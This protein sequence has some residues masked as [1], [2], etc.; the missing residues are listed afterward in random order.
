MRASR[1][2]RGDPFNHIGACPPTVITKVDGEAGTGHLDCPA[3]PRASEALVVQ[4]A[5][6]AVHIT[7][8][9]GHDKDWGG[10]DDGGLTLSVYLQLSNVSQEERVCESA[11]S[12]E[13]DPWQ[14]GGEG[15]RGGCSYWPRPLTC[16]SSP[17]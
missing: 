1:S 4:E 6:V 10:V 15:G 12:A 9:N 13:E 16:T 3:K 2:H 5:G 14:A 8:G 17:G 7:E 11:E